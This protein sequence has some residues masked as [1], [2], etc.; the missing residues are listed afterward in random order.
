M[1][2]LKRRISYVLP[3]PSPDA[4]P[5]LLS[6]PPFDHDKK[7]HPTPFI[8]PKAAPTFG[9]RNPFLQ[10]KRDSQQ[11][12]SPGHPQ[13]CLGVEALALDT[14]TVL[15]GDSSPG[16]ILYTAGRDGLVAS[17]D[18][19]IPHT[20]R[21]SP[22]YSSLDGK[23]KP[24]RIRWESIGDD[25]EFFED[26]DE[27]DPAEGSGS[28]E[29]WVD[30]KK[31]FDEVPYE[32]RWE[33]DKVE[34]A[35]RSPQTTFRQS[36]QTHT[37]WVNAMLLCNYN[38]TAI[39]ASSDRTIRAWTPHTSGDDESPS[40]PALIGTHDDYVKSLAWAKGHGYLWSGGLDQ[41][42]HL[43][44]VKETRGSDPILT[45]PITDA[46]DQRG[47]VYTLGTDQAGT[48]L[49]AGTAERTVRLWDARSGP[50]STGYLI[51]HEDRVRSILIS[52]SGKYMLTGSADSTIKLW[53][54]SAHRCL[55]TFTHSSSSI[56][57]LF[58]S[59]PNLERFYSGSRDG[60]LCA[61]DFE[62]CGDISQGE[63]V[64]LAREGEVEENGRRVGGTYEGEE[65]IRSIVAMDDE[66]VW[67]STGSAD[68]HRWRDVGRRISRLDK[69]FGGTSFKRRSWLD[70]N[71]LSAVDPIN[72]RLLDSGEDGLTRTDT[73]DS[74]SISFAPVPAVRNNSDEPASPISPVS[75]VPPALRDR[76][77]H[78]SSLST[79]S[80]VS[81]TTTPEEEDVGTRNGLPYSA[82]VNLAPDEGVYGFGAASGSVASFAR[83]P[84]EPRQPTDPIDPNKRSA[85]LNRDVDSA[86]I[87]LRP[88]PDEDGRIQ[89]REG[90][91][92]SGTCLDKQHVV[93]VDT[94]GGVA[95]WNIM[96]GL[97]I[98]IFDW[99]EI[100]E[101]FHITVK[102]NGEAAVRKQIRRHASDVIDLVRKRVDG[103]VEIFPWLAGIDTKIGSLVVHLDEGR[104]FD[105]DAFADELGLSGGDIDEDIRINLGKWA[106]SNL[107]RGLILAEE[108]EV[109]SQVPPLSS[110]SNPAFLEA[111]HAP[112]RMR[113]PSLSTPI[114]RPQ[115]SAHRKRAMTG[116][117]S[118]TRPTLN[119]PVT[120]PTMGRQAVFL[121]MPDEEAR[122]GGREEGWRGFDTS[123]AGTPGRMGLS[124]PPT[125]ESHTFGMG[126]GVLSNSYTSA[127]GKDY[128]SPRKTDPSPPGN[129]NG[130]GK[131]SNGS[132]GKS[133]ATPGG[134]GLM[135]KLKNLGKKKTAESA[136]PAV[137][138]REIF[139][140]DT[141]PKV[142]ERDAA[143]LEML[144]LVRSHHFHP[145]PPHE[146]PPIH[147][148]P[149]TTLLLSEQVGNAGAWVV[150]YRSQVSTTER[151]MEALEMNSPM[152]LLDCIFANRVKEKPVP[153]VTFVLKPQQGSSLPLLSETSRTVF[154]N[155][156]LRAKRI[157]THIADK[158]NDATPS[159]Q[160]KLTP[161]DL[162]LFLAQK[163][164]LGVINGRTSVWQLR[165]LA[166]NKSEVLVY[167][168]LKGE[169]VKR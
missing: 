8:L 88:T 117:F 51:G 46:D 65:G 23:K 93:T 120:S 126:S 15:E 33:V 130:G 52:D 99:Q 9:S 125:V 14:T 95:I 162:E 100:A 167:Y 61:I 105:A 160:T 24:K 70:S 135:G 109:T 124:G 30:M 73:R 158:L 34:L 116:S 29:E 131:E 119:I 31:K 107:F 77:N 83:R 2:N 68:V 129:A 110:P 127:S 98:G 137:Q 6:L 106:L 67:T 62:G 37:D 53:S 90:L 122:E 161:D 121:D 48:T 142:S 57:S 22:R 97:C 55:H 151:D 102:P 43:W 108:H 5:P 11:R 145:P 39:T 143:Q 66:Y 89:G 76:L 146:A 58:S 12:K 154:A 166:E 147:Y 78:R 155:R 168:A 159:T 84:D 87:P 81:D 20:R 115:T 148:P 75:A 140:E 112:S 111:P 40:T 69:D 13:H 72:K 47:S 141:G 50:K 114:D 118:K 63:C 42:I 101:A 79:S 64:V 80:F 21:F 4:P 54:L 96:S 71:P 123:K 38:R 32:D 153:R 86:A 91:I 156:S 128:F 49:A 44:D 36:A 35:K 60:H 134:G 165:T 136:M 152:W 94:L 17:W 157:Y 41:K 74:R 28:D 163:S 169:S 19:D 7:G 16:G 56:W 26:D 27:V 82:L 25:A 3:N 144:D 59:H 45:V 1:S 149:N 138:E 150:T 139:K 132:I 104:V 85:F 92:R 113:A 164:E 18:L 10:T 103:E 133:P